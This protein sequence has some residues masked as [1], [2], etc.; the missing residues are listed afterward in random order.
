[1]VA[2]AAFAA[3][4]GGATD[5]PRPE[6]NACVPIP[7]FELEYGFDDGGSAPDCNGLD[8]YELFPLNLFDVAHG[9]S[10]YLNND[11]TAMQTPV[12]DSQG[13][14][15]TQIPGGRC[16]GAPRSERAPSVCDL[17]ETERGECNG[18]FSPDSWDALEI[19]TGNMTGNGGIFG[20]ILPKRDCVLPDQGDPATIC[21]FTPGP[22]EVGPCSIGEG[23]SPPLVGCLAQQDFGGW[24]G[25]VFWGRVG[26][27][28]ESAIRVRASDPYT[29]DKACR[30]NPYTSQNDASDGC[31]KFGAYAELDRTFR[32]VFVRFDEM[33]QGGWGLPRPSLDTQNILE[34]AFEYGAG[35]WDLWLDDVYLF[36]S[37]P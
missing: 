32:P 14:A 24:E 6:G 28:S 36:R 15:T 21:P 8:G 11:R 22:P 2:L 25:V 35:T 34:I 27:G 10:P 23:P 9:A 17:A 20:I 18:E 1:V 4:C 19:K 5:T 3:A 13:V 12:P 33:Q 30:C 7:D 26:P 29:D 37:R 31:D 16:V